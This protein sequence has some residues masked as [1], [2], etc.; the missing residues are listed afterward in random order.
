MSQGTQL[1]PDRPAQSPNR[2]RV[3]LA[4]AGVGIVAAV[5]GVA[6]FSGNPTKKTQTA[7]VAPTT[8]A[9]A[10]TDAP[11]TTARPRGPVA[12]LTG[13]PTTTAKAKRCSVMVKIGNTAE[14]SPQA[15]LDAAD[16]VYEEVVD[17]G[18]T[19]L[20]AVFQSHAPTKVG[21]LRSTRPTDHD[22]V[23]P[24]GGVFAFSGG[25][26][27]ELNAMNGVSAQMVDETAA[28]PMFTRDPSRS[29]PNN[30][31]AD[32][33][34]LYARC[35]GGAPP[36]L[37]SYRRIGTQPAG[38]PAN[39]GTVGFE[40]GYAVSWRWNSKTRTYRA[41]SSGPPTSSRASG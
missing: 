15:G 30:L 33:S 39:V 26:A 9:V 41:R 37:F 13:L 40:S 1:P 14:A 5:V 34:Q 12:P 22:L 27:I 2:R 8:T 29:V 32:V 10:T 21:G 7:G 38:T 20:A 3:G 19:R 35:P 4:A 24:L 6:A 18:I 23:Q 28:G 17:G 16:V 36:Q 31:F 25:N 11:S